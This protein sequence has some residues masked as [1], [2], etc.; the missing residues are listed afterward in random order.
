M[1]GSGFATREEFWRLQSTL[2]GLSATQSQHAERI[3]RLEKKSEDGGRTKSLWGPSSPFPSGLNTSHTESTLNPAAEAFR[4]FDNETPSGII[5]SLTLDNNDEARRAASRAASVRFDES[6]NHYAPSRQSID[7]PTRTGSGLGSH[8]LSERSLSHRSDGRSSTAGFGRANSFGLENSRLLGSIHNSPRV[9]GNPP[10]GLFVLA[11]CPAIVRCWLTETFTNDSLLYAVV[12]TGAASSSIGMH[13]LQA[14]GLDGEVVEE[15]GLKKI[16]LLVYLTEAKVQLPS[17]RSASPSPQ[18]P[19]ITT[20]FIVDERPA[21]DKSIQIV[22]G[23]DVL[24][25][26]SADILLS[27][28]KLVIYDDDRNQLSVPLVR[29]EDDNVYRYLQTR[30]RSRSGSMVSE[31]HPSDVVSEMSAPGIIGRPSRLSSVHGSDSPV[32][33]VASSG[34]LAS[35]HTADGQH[36]EEP[37]QILTRSSTDLQSRLGDDSK[38]GTESDKSATTPASKSSSGVWSN[39]WRSAAATSNPS[40]KAAD[41]QA[42]SIFTRTSG[43]RQMKVLRTGKSMANVNRTAS[44]PSTPVTSSTPA[45]GQAQQENQDSGAT[46]PAPTRTNPIGS[47]TAFGWLTSDASRKSTTSGGP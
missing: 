6:A 2:D 34:A 16:R 9:S 43:P 25:Q 1:D 12:C 15:T 11:P 44:N 29:P 10:A 28:D 13:T 19:T 42:S 3:M 5:S 20:K 45:G 30:A 27:Q 21:Q 14:L 35:S 37:R 24:R 23:S 22:I 32:P 8:P 4:N 47:G 39:S 33:D 26:Q 40:A 17:S 38:S 41:S 36:K 18:V 7:V 31:A 46:Q